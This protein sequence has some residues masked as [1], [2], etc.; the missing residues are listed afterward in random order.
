MQTSDA[1]PSGRTSWKRLALVMVPT[2]ATAGALVATMAS[3]ALATS[4]GVSATSFPV[5]G[6]S[7][8]IASTRLEGDGFVQFGVVDRGRDGLYPEALSGIRS[9]TLHHLCQSVVQNVPLL[10]PV[11]LRFTSTPA[12]ADRLIANAHDLRGDAVFQ[13]INIGQDAGTVR[14]V[15]GVQGTPGTFGEQASSVVI[16][17]LRQTTRSISAATFRLPDLH[18]TV[19]RG[20]HSCF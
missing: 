17:D 6:E 15:P 18:L 12:H 13:N 7:F 11:T 10:G 8:Q 3:G 16:G 5:A 14:G 20:D 2:L 9:A 19:R 1:R 4:F